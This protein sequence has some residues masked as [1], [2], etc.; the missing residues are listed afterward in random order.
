M[1]KA[2]TD[3]AGRYLYGAA[4]IGFGLCALIWHDISGVRQFQAF[5]SAGAREILASLVGAVEI[6]AGTAVLWTG[7]SRAGAVLLGALY[8]AFA[9]LGVPYVIEQPSVYNNYGNVFEQLA[10]ASGAMMLV[11]D[12]IWTR[13]GFVAFCACLV[14]FALEQVFY[15]AATAALVPAW[16]PPGRYFWACATTA[17]FVLAAVAMLTGVLAPLAARL[18]AAMI[19]GFGVLVW[20]PALVTDPRAAGN[21]SEG[22]ETFAIA[23]S[24]WIAAGLVARGRATARRSVAP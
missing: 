24:A 15:L 8:G 22:I 14:S 18:N 19:L 11:T 13:I 12:S 1:R 4:A 9:L 17:A 7:T 21:W 2:M 23:G 16:I 6:L 3:S 10:L 5:G 20:V